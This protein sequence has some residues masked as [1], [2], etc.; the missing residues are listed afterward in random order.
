MEWSFRFFFTQPIA[1]NEMVGG[2][3][4]HSASDSTLAY[5]TGPKNLRHSGMLLMTEEVCHDPMLQS[6]RSL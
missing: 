3:N 6:Q 2:W 5:Q 1:R 4:N